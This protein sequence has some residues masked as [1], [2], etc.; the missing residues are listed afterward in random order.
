MT[1]ATRFR[2][3]SWGYYRYFQQSVVNGNAPNDT[4]CQ[5]DDNAG[6]LCF[7]GGRSTT[8]G[9]G[10]IS[11]FLGGGQYGQLDTQPTSTHAYG[12]GLQVTDTGKLFGRDNHFVAGASL[13]IGRTQFN[14]ASF[15][16]GLTSSDRS[17][18]GP[19]VVIDEPGTN[20]PVSVAVDS[21][22][23]GFYLPTP[24]GS[25]RSWR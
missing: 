13:D 14:A 15:V 2:C 21:A 20:S 23:W 6:L 1:W 11:D 4:P 18:V 22:S 17:F 3:R 7:S 16:G 9:G 10:F 8:A 24:G 19:G 5:D 25:R 12:G